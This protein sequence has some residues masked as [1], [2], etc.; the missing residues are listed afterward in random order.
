MWYDWI[1]SPLRI[2]L[3]SNEFYCSMV[4][5]E[6]IK[7]LQ[8]KKE[9]LFFMCFEKGDYKCRHWIF[10]LSVLKAMNERFG[11]VWWIS[12]IAP[13]PWCALRHG[14]FRQS[15]PC[16]ILAM[17]GWIWPQGVHRKDHKVDFW[18][19]QPSLQ[20]SWSKIQNG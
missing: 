3:V 13:H 5:L 7:N 18:I 6:R 11:N 9:W 2:D 19:M 1:L 15:G 14:H 4:R 16:N 12:T 17:L 10:F 8:R 20:P